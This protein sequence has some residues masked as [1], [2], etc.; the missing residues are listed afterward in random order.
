MFF[1]T[2]SLHCDD[3]RLNKICVSLK[4]MVSSALWDSS[5]SNTTTRLEN[6]H[7]AAEKKAVLFP[8]SL[9]WFSW[10]QQ[11]LHQNLSY[12]IPSQPTPIRADSGRPGYKLSITPPALERGNTMGRGRMDDSRVL[13]F[14]LTVFRL[15]C[16][17]I[18]Y[19][20]TPVVGISTLLT[21]LRSRES[22]G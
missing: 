4:E 19:N 2:D 6:V 12:C 13:F 5:E 20:G 10:L 11:R 14:I 16:S 9:A 17:S 8:L 22:S 18:P 3:S 15:H 7:L 1:G 21:V